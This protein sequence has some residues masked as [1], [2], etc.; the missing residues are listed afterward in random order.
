M[1]APARTAAV[2]R[3]GGGG[4]DG[5]EPGAERGPPGAAPPSRGPHRAAPSCLLEEGAG[6]PALALP[7]APAELGSRPRAAPAPGRGRA[8]EGPARAGRG[9]RGA[10]APGS[11][12]AARGCG[13]RSHARSRSPPSPP[14]AIPLG[15]GA[16]APSL[17]WT[18]FMKGKV[19]L[20]PP[21]SEAGSFCL[22]REANGLIRPPTSRAER[23]ESEA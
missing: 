5:S 10:R 22:G 7:G 8:G 23:N 3:G 12:G 2:H 11:R 4:G 15:F 16:A 1:A 18:P 13:A 21:G 17:R 14:R 19:A 20:S 6:T 9:V